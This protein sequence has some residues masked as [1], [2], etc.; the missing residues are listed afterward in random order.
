[1][2]RRPKGVALRV[3]SAA[4]LIWSRPSRTWSHQ[5]TPGG[6][7][8]KAC[9]CGRDTLSVT[10]SW[11]DAS[12]P[13]K[14]C[15]CKYRARSC[16]LHCF[17]CWTGSGPLLPRALRGGIHAGIA[18]HICYL[19]HVGVAANAPGSCQGCSLAPE[20]VQHQEQFSTPHWHP[21]WLF[22]GV[23]GTSGRY[24]EKDGF[25]KVGSPAMLPTA[26][27]VSVPAEP[28]NASRK[29]ASRQ[30]KRVQ[31]WKQMS[32]HNGPGLSGFDHAPGHTHCTPAT[33]CTV[34]T[35]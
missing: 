21:E 17:R 28:Q 23:N 15:A 22:F 30:R 32:S 26:P 18:T 2:P 20:P 6:S 11:P 25:Q 8:L 10:Q 33:A 24:I 3:A 1:M 34:P 5:H 14:Q 7:C 19:P 35:A 31:Q 9:N 29:G 4:A 27:F 12:Q 13:Q 16:A